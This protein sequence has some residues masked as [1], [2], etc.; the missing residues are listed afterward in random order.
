MPGE[1]AGIVT[2]LD[3]PQ[4]IDL[5]TASYGQG[6][7]LTPIMMVRALTALANKGVLSSPH[8]VKKINYKI[9]LS[10]KIEISPGER[11][12]SEETAEKITKMLVGVVD[13]AL[14]GG[15]VKMKEYSIAAKTGTAQISK[16]D[17][18][19]YEESAFLHSFFGY[20]PAYDP[21]FLIFLYALRPEGATF[22]S[23][24]LTRPFMDIV[25]FLIGFYEIPPDR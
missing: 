22:A 10:K 23:E 13:K 24:T 3:K 9:G 6:I 14:L 17:T 21:K 19:G 2:N 12:I 16:K 7:A 15:S 1:I 11:V 18:G 8:L 5:A 25:K 4:E 20:F